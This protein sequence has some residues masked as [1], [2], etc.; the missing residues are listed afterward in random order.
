M[1][2]GILAAGATVLVAAG[3]AGWYLSSR[4][5][6]HEDVSAAVAK[7]CKQEFATAS[8]L[9]SGTTMTVALGETDASY[10]VPAETL[11]RA[12]SKLNALAADANDKDASALTVVANKLA[13]VSQALRDDDIAMAAAAGATAQSDVNT[14]FGTDCDNPGG[15]DE[16]AKDASLAGINA[17][18]DRYRP[19]VAE[20]ADELNDLAEVS[21]A[22]GAESIDLVG[23]RAKRFA[24]AV[25]ATGVEGSEEMVDQLQSASRSAITASSAWSSGLYAESTTEARE[26]I[27]TLFAALDEGEN[28]GALSCSREP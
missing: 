12:R 27:K 4:G 6:S 8:G 28:L 19:L 14:A 18:C 15:G 26:M 11:D 24:S 25:A 21:D 10:D 2:R 5:P 13:D 20:A 3:G 17:A 16:A 22:A 7:I 1:K 9:V 23:S